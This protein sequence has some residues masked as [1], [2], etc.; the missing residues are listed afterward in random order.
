M[1]SETNLLYY[2]KKVKMTHSN[3]EAS[4]K[5]KQKHYTIMY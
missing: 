3:Y 1:K 5:V 4:G 2:E